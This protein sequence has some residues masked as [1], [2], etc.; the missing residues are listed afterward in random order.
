MAKCNITFEFNS[1]AE[2]AA[3][4]IDSNPTSSAPSVKTTGPA[5]AGGS[6]IPQS[7][8]Q[9]AAVTPTAPPEGVTLEIV[10]KAMTDYVGKGAGRTAATAREI[11]TK[12]G[13]AALKDATP[14]QLAAVYPEFLNG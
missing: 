11:L 4:L 13:C 5:Q 12:H 9:P 8:Q 10:R 3:F 1:P 6:V 2:A 7:T 14:E